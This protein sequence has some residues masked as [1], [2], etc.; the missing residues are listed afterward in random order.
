MSGDAHAATTPVVDNG[1]TVLSHRDPSHTGA[2]GVTFSFQAATQGGGPYTNQGNQIYNLPLYAAGTADSAHFWTNEVEELVSAGVDFVAVDTRGYIPGSTVPNE[3]GDPRALTGLV[4]AINQAGVADKLKIAAFD[5]T[6]ASM[7]D[8]KNQVKHHAGGYSPP[9]DMGDTNGSGEGGYQYL[10]DNDLKSF[11]QAVPDS[12]LYKVNGQPLVYLWSDNAFAFSNQGNGN[13]ARLLTYVRN[14]AKST[15]NENPYFV[16]DQSWIKNDPAVSSVANGQDGWFGVPTPTYTNMSLNGQSFG[17]TTPSFHFVTNSSNMVIDPQHGQT[18]VNNL[19]ATVDN[20]DLLTLVEGF[21][22]WPENC[23]LWR[24]EDAPYATTQRD[25][26]G[27]DL[28]ILR[29]YS[30]TPFPTDFTVQAETADA[31]HDTT[32]GNQFGVYRGDD[33]D[34]QTT[35]DTHGGWNVGATATGEWEQWN[36]VPMQGTTDMKIRVASPNTGEQLR[37][38]VDGVAGPTISVPNTGGWQNWQTIDAGTFQFK[39]GTYHA[40]QIQQVTGGYNLNWWQATRTDNPETVVDDSQLTYDANWHAS[41]DRGLGDYDDDVHHSETVGAAASYTFT[42]TGI[43]YLSERNGDMGNV[44]VY[45]D[46]VLQANVNLKVSGARQSQ[47]VVWS[48]TGLTSGTHTLRIVNKTG[49]V[50]M[51]DALRVHS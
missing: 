31:V 11:F 28:N 14:Q 50:G 16:V 40:V 6:P 15:F 4:N 42:G 51:I 32:S 3:G 47:Q 1:G 33:L 30:K 26:P 38:V 44:D 5:D 8:K 34:V 21:T 37:F 36:E 48:K 46:N 9:F 13:S 17:A 20:G 18:L 7:T 22:D 39:P 2:L 27:Q 49:A 10:W 12:M 35:T 29:R 45:L 25:Y 24:T 19:H 23:A 43:D 41:S